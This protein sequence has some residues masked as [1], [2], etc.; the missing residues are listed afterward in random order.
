MFHYYTFITLSCHIVVLK[1]TSVIFEVAPIALTNVHVFVCDAYAS[2]ISVPALKL[3]CLSAIYWSNGL[4]PNSHV[5][6]KE[7]SFHAMWHRRRTHA[8]T[9]NKK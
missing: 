9:P 7:S 2:A 5:G 1:M 4:P 8:R 6:K 3:I